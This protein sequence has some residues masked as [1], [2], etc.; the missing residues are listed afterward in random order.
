MIAARREVKTCRGYMERNPN[1]SLAQQF[2]AVQGWWSEA[3]VD[4]TYSD[5]RTCWLRDP[6]EDAA[7]QADD[8]HKPVQLEKTSPVIIPPQQRIGGDPE[9]WPRT[10]ESFAEWWLSEPSLDDAV[11]QQRIPPRGRAGA[12]LMVLVPEPEA[13]DTD[14]LLSG[15]QGRL[16]ANFLRAA[17]VEEQDAYIAS[18]LPRHTPLPDWQEL[19]STGLDAVIRHHIHLAEPARLLVFG[20]GIL[21]LIGNNP[22]QTSAP[23][24][25]INHQGRTIGVL[26]ARS[27]DFMLAR[28]AVRSG[29]WQRWLDWTDR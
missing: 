1:L 4:L 14:R 7:T 25:E 9:N 16:L 29:F 5:A 26:G 2:D 19:G 10:F 8:P 18:V 3:G 21:P 28:P 24:S 23:L 6:E 11:A 12:K 17:G 20:R 22:A 15:P 27:L 13:Q